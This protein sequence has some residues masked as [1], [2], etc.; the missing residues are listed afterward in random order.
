L[1]GD[2]ESESVPPTGDQHYLDTQ[3][4]GAPDGSHIS[5]GNDELGVEKGTVDIDAQQ[6]Y[7]RGQHRKVYHPTSRGK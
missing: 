6:A 3:R 1:L 2:G 4:V 5:F 7:G